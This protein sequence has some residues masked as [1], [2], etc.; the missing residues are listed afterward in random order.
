[1]P[2]TCRPLFELAGR[3]AVT[4]IGVG[5]EWTQVVV[6]K[7]ESGALLIV[8]FVESETDHV[9]FKRFDAVAP[10]PGLRLLPHARKL[11]EFPGTGAVWSALAAGGVT[12]RDPNKQS[13]VL[14]PHPT[15]KSTK[16]RARITRQYFT[17]T[18]L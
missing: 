18:I 14:V 10:Q 16:E 11:C 13:R 5:V 4:V 6:P 9:T 3:V 8:T 1:M 7:V 2:V 17:I 12:F 15:N